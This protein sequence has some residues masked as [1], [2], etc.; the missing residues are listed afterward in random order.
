[1]Y[2]FYNTQGI[3]KIVSLFKIYIISNEE[4]FMNFLFRLGQSN[5]KVFFEFFTYSSTPARYG[6]SSPLTFIKNENINTKI[7]GDDPLTQAVDGFATN[8]QFSVGV[9]I[10]DQSN[11]YSQKILYNVTPVFDPVN[12]NTFQSLANRVITQITN[13]E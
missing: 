4:L 1:M 10:I 9:Q 3:K 12:T 6:L 11:F 7:Y 2:P 8:Q 13:I 5:L